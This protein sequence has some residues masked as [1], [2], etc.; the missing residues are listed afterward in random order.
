MTT[1][2]GSGWQTAPGWSLKAAAL[3]ALRELDA[4]AR[5]QGSPV[6]FT[7]GNVGHRVAQLGHA[8]YVHRGGGG[9][10]ARA[11]SA[12]MRALV[13]SG[14]AIESFSSL[15]AA[16]YRLSPKGRESR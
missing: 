1:R 13:R 8:V 4:E 2:R 9:S 14:D 16:R 12:T 15:S 7:A 10:A 3:V 11:L 5:E 6:E